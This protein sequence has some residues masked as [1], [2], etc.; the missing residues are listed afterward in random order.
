MSETENIKVVAAHGDDYAALALRQV[1]EVLPDQCESSLGCRP[2]PAARR[3]QDPVHTCG[4][5]GRINVMRSNR[6][7][8][9]KQEN[10]NG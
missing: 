4:K 8:A 6:R 9:V 1:L 3:W 10:E 5:N 2:A 7:T